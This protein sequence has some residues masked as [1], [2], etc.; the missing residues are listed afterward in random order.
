MNDAQF[1]EGQTAYT[2][3]KGL[4]AN[5]YTP[6]LPEYL[7]WNAGWEFNEAQED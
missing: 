3:G 1:K 6:G 5:P 7:A 4:D 2:D